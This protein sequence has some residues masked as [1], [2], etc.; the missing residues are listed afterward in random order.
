MALS[1]EAEELSDDN[2]FRDDEKPVLDKKY[3]S[4]FLYPPL[5]NS[6]DSYRVLQLLPGK[7]DEQVECKIFHVKIGDDCVKYEALSYTW[8]NPTKIHQIPLLLNGQEVWIT[9]NLSAAL[10][11]LRND[12]EPRNLWIDAICINQQ[13]IPERQ[14][15]V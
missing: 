3:V 7:A 5:G 11:C 9:R 14:S 8:G 1:L 12:K 2:L 10:R 6:N 13:D 4:N 15:Q